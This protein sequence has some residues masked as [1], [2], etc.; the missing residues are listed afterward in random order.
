MA[1]LGWNPGDDREIFS[2]KELIKEFSLEKVG[3]AGAVFNLEKLNWYNKEY[4]KRLTDEEL[5]KLAMPFL[6][7]KIGDRRYEISELAKIIALEKER[8][9]TLAELPEALSFIFDLPKYPSDLLVWKKSSAEEVKRFC[10][11]CPRC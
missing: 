1:F 8:V 11:N 7:K 10:R 3:K 6:E 2:L 4:L 9:T 5:V